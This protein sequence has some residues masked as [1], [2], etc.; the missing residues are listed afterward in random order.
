MAIRFYKGTVLWVSNVPDENGV[1]HKDR[2]VLLVADCSESD[3]LIDGIAVT[4]SYT[5]PLSD[6]QFKLPFG[7]PNLC[8]SGLVLPSV[9]VCDWIVTATQAQI[10]RKIGHIKSAK[11]VEILARMSSL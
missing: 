9:A 4:S 11:L 3:L 10:I 5:E 8:H 1:N 2:P 6:V 7:R